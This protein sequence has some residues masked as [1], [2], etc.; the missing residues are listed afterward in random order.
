MEV[1]LVAELALVTV[2]VVLVDLG[3]TDLEAAIEEAMEAVTVALEATE[4]LEV[5]VSLSIY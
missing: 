4:D 1:A 2:L 3:T 5:L